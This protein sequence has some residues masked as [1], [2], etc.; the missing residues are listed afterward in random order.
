M[1]PEFFQTLNLLILILPIPANIAAYFISKKWNDKIDIDNLILSRYYNRIIAYFFDNILLVGVIGGSIWLSHKAFGTEFIF[2]NS[3]L[4]LLLTGTFCILYFSLF[5]S[6]PI[7]ATIGKWLLDIQ[8]VDKK[9][10]RLTIKLALT[11]TL[12][13]L[14]SDLSYLGYLLILFT[15][16]SQGFHEVF[17]GTLV[18]CKSD[19]KANA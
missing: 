2:E 19:L 8:I 16:Y 18:V 3:T 6:S 12:L 17:T 10:K 13:S 11:R 7:Q 5:E 9:G 15:K 1:P 4:L 14:F